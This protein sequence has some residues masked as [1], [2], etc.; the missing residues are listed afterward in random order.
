MMR[1]ILKHSLLGIL[2]L[3]TCILYISFKEPERHGNIKFIIESALQIPS[4]EGFSRV[5]E[6][7]IYFS[8]DNNRIDKIS[9]QSFVHKI[10]SF[11]VQ[12][13]P[14]KIELLADLSF[15][16]SKRNLKWMYYSSSH[17]QFKF[18]IDASLDEHEDHYRALMI[19]VEEIKY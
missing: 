16:F 11:F 19:T 5:F 2:F 1:I 12:N 14:Y 10:D 3:T 9:K 6:D 8:V 18:N 15:D 13:N 7:S 17:K 4:A